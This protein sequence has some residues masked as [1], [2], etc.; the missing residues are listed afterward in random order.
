MS[1]PQ[2][3]RHGNIITLTFASEE[4]AKAF[5]LNDK[6]KIR[7]LEDEIDKLKHEKLM[8]ESKIKFQE[9]DIATNKMMLEYVKG[10]YEGEKQRHQTTEK[11]LRDTQKLLDRTLD[12]EESEDE[13]QFA[14]EEFQFAKVEDDDDTD[15]STFDTDTD[16]E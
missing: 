16:S 15:T 6:G 1:R 8:L 9:F 14:N 13:I 2:V 4:D 11:M 5:K 3:A 12:L 7:C 10:K